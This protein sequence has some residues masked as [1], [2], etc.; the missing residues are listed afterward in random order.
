MPMQTS[1]Q[2]LH[3]GVRNLVMQFTGTAD[4]SD[5]ETNVVKVRAA[6]L[7]PAG[8]RQIT[9]RRVE[10]S[11]NGG[12]LRILWNANDPQVFLDLE[13]QGSFDYSKTSGAKN[14]AGDEANGD[15]LFTTLGFDSGSNYSVKLDMVKS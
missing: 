15:I 9:V 5:V 7:D 11:V 6:D 8:S 4:G 3:D 1:I 14:G 2:T 10:Y 13:G 12:V